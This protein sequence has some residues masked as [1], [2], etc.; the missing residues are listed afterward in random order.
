MLTIRGTF[1]TSR[2][3][4]SGEA[5]DTPRSFTEKRL[6]NLGCFL[7]WFWFCIPGTCPEEE[8]VDTK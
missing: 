8:V 1:V 4:K 3:L 6:N 5:I 2:V 7:L